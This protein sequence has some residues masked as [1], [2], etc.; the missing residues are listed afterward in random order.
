MHDDL[1]AVNR[2]LREEIDQLRAELTAANSEREQALLEL[3]TVR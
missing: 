3:Q 2:E 1:E